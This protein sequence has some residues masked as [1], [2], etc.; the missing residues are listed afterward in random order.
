MTQ[1][2]T[3]IDTPVGGLSWEYTKSLKESIKELFVF[4]KYRRLLTNPIYLEVPSQCADSAIEIKN[5]LVAFASNNKL[6]DEDQ[7]VVDE[8]IK[9]SNKFLDDLNKVQEF[10]PYIHIGD[11]LF[12]YALKIY[13]DAI[14]NGIEYFS[15]KYKVEFDKEI[16][17]KPINLKWS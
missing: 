12:A 1:R 11:D 8:M 4:F 7:F 16:L 14:K 9:S 3:G 10:V 17:N 15:D 13:R 2:I 5:T 6:T